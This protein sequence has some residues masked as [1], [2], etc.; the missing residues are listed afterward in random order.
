MEQLEV[1]HP[2]TNESIGVKPRAEVIKDGH[3]CRSTNVF[4]L[5]SEGQIL[6]HQRSL[7]KERNPGAWSTHMGGH[8]G[9][10]ETYETNAIKEL[11][12]EAGIEV[13]PA[14][15]LSWRTTKIPNARLWV[16]EFVTV[17]DKPADHFSPQVGEVDQF[18]W[19]HLQEILDSYKQQPH[20]WLAGTHDLLTEYQCMR[21]VLAAAGSIGLVPGSRKLH[22]WHP[23]HLAIA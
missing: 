22:V 13:D 4:V 2:L 8:V 14:H 19:K 7:E 16:R 23:P 15:V 18:A 5:N 21:A 17:I 12:E 1:V 10:G 11:Q 3:W 20:N 9:V 6:C